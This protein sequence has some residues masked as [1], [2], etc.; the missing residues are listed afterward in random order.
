MKKI[1]F[2]ILIALTLCIGFAFADEYEAEYPKIVFENKLD[3]TKVKAGDNFEV[4]IIVK[5]VGN[6]AA[7]YVNIANSDK[8]AP[9]YWETAVDT[10]SINRMSS[11]SKK[12]LKLNLCVKETADVGI[13]ELPFDITYSNYSGNQYTNKQTLYFE[14][15][16]EKSKPLMELKNIKTN[17]SEVV[18]NSEVKLSFDLFNSGDLLA[19]RVKL[20]LDGTG[21]STFMIKD[22]I[23]TRYFD[24]LDGKESRQVEF[25]LLVSEDIEEG[26]HE[27][28]VKLEYFDQDNKSYSDTKTF[29]INNVK[30]ISGTSSKSSPKIII[31]SYTASPSTVV[32]GK[33]VKLTFKLKNTHNSKA[34]VNMKSVIDT[35]GTT[36][37]MAGGSNSFYI[38][39]LEPQ[40]EIE[41]TI[42]LKTKQDALSK[43]YPINIT[44]DYEDEKGTSY[45]AVETIN[46]PVLEK[47]NLSINNIYG[48]YEMYKGNTGYVSFEYYN[49]GKA[50]ISN[51]RVTV[52]GDYSPVGEVY[53]GNVDAGK[54]SYSEIEVRAEGA[55]QAH[56]KLI[57]S[58][59]DSSGNVLK[60]T[61]SIEGFIYT[62]Q[63]T[64]NNEPIFIPEMPMEEVK[65]TMA[66]WLV[67]LISAGAFV[68]VMIVTRAIVIKIGMKKIEEEI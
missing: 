61:R 18:A 37:S 7:K 25:D 1:I 31:S 33:D 68:L 41:K 19:R 62:E 45:N 50:T 28:N 2:S 5:N 52:E 4:N 27:L 46:L 12:E 67:G 22:A 16:E 65:E 53:I 30:G 63:P 43:A 66:W 59:E 17:P 38:E 57:F 60:E 26:T 3:I 23:D 15:T 35:D 9:I 55:E 20:T 13:Y 44:S 32:A 24:L 49:M 51:L 10:Y 14:V 56:G 29:Y 58:F 39:R 64:F 21:K 6:E 54:G 47:T 42:T 34:I 11:G 40:Q 8:N 48:P 36:L